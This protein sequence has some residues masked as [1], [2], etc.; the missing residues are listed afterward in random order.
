MIKDSR[1]YPLTGGWGFTQFNDGKP[2]DEAIRNTCFSC[3][4][5]MKIRDFIFT[6]YAS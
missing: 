1:K 5:P 3:H 4:E 6:R 2:V